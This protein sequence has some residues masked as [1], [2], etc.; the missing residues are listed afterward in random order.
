MVRPAHTDFKGMS[1]MRY[2]V[3]NRFTGEVQFTADIDCADCA[4][5]PV[6]LAI[7]II[8]AVK[9]GAN[10]TYANLICANLGL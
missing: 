6:K 8:S 2:E 4:S 10:L 9:T 3:T 1:E 5:K 7:A